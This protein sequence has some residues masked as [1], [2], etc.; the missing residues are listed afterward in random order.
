MHIVRELL[1][2]QLVVVLRM[3]PSLWRQVIWRSHESFEDVLS[4][5]LDQVTESADVIMNSIV[6]PLCLPSL[7]ILTS[8]QIIRLEHYLRLVVSWMLLLLQQWHL[9]PL[10]RRKSFKQLLPG[11]LNQST[12]VAEVLVNRIIDIL[13]D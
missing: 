1:V 6:D 10:L 9:A 3:W 4:C 8:A 2:H 13:I 12:E 7:L 5:E 11:S